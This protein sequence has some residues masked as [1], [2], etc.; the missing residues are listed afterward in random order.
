M[1]CCSDVVQVGTSDGV[2]VLVGLSYDSFVDP[3]AAGS[4]RCPTNFGTNIGTKS[5]A[6]VIPTSGKV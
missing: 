2:G 3:V 6:S 5:S 1:N 4:Q